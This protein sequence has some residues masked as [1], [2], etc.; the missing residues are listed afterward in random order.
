MDG[1]GDSAATGAAGGPSGG[2]GPGETS[3][4]P[5]R[6][7]QRLTGSALGFELDAEAAALRTE[8]AWARFDRNAKTLVKEGGLRVVLTVLRAGARLEPHRADAHVVAQVLRGRLRVRL[9]EAGDAV[10]LPAGALLALRPGVA[11]EVE[12]LEERALLLTVAGGRG[13]PDAAP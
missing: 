12:A 5:E 2:H 9:P 4:S 3:P 8:A 7:A 10:E 13:G 6:A 11:H 1:D